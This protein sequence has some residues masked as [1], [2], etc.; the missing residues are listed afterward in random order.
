M[1]RNMYSFLDREIKSLDKLMGVIPNDND[2]FNLQN[3][4]NNLRLKY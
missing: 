4:L 2:R 3:D 1:K